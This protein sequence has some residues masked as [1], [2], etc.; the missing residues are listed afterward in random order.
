MFFATCDNNRFLSVPCSRARERGAKL[1][2]KIR[3]LTVIADSDSA[4]VQSECK[5]RD[6]FDFL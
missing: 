2:Y 4:N 1:G 6:N 3:D 5:E